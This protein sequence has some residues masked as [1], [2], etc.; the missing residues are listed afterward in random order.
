LALSRFLRVLKLQVLAACALLFWQSICFADDILTPQERTWLQAHPDIRVAISP[1]YPPISF[2]DAHGKPTGLE[3]DYLALIEKR[4]NY[5]FKRV[6]PTLAQRSADKPE[7]KQADVVPT[8]ASTSDRLQYWYFTQPYLDFP[9]YLITQGNAPIKFSL[10][11]S[12]QKQVSVV[13]HYAV[14]EYLINKFPNVKVDKVDDTCIG[15]QHVSSGESA[16]ML[17]DLPV[18]NWCAKHHDLK[19]FKIAQTT[20]F[21]YQLS[22]ASRKD[23][24]ELASILE[25][26]LASIKQ[27]ERDEIYLRWN[28]NSLEEQTTFEKNKEWI[29]TGVFA[30]LGL[31]LYRLYRWDNKFKDSLDKHFNDASLFESTQAQHLAASKKIMQT[32][33]IAFVVMVLIIFSI[34]IFTYDYFEKKESNLLSIV[35]FVVVGMGLLGGFTLGSLWRRFQADASFS[36]LQNQTKQRELAERQLTQMDQRQLKQQQTLATLTR[37]QL[38]PWQVAED[39]YREIA[40]QAAETLEAERASV[41]LFDESQQQL[42]CMSMFIKSKQ[43]HTVVKPLLANL[44]PQYFKHLIAQRVVVADD[45]YTNPA[46]VEF[47]TGYLLENNIGAMLDGT[48]WLNNEIVGVVCIEHVGGT[49]EWTLDEQNFVGSLTDY[50]RVIIETCNRRAAEQALMQQTAQLEQI[51][52]ERTQALRESEGRYSYVIQHAPIPILVIAANGSIMD[53]NPEALLAGGYKREDVIGKNFIET[54][55]A[56][57]S[58][59][60]A[61]STAALILKGNDFRDVELVLQSSTGEKVEYLCSIGTTNLT[62][63]T[64]AGEMVAIAQDISQ[65]KVLQSSLIKAREAAESADRIKSMFVASMSHELRTPLNSIIGFLGVVL[66]GMSGELNVKQKDQLGRAY[67]SA[68]HLLWLI[69]DVID[70]SKI[71]AGFLQVHTE[72]VYLK[73]LFI[74]VEHAVSHLAEEKHLRLDI[75]CEDTLQLLTDRKRIYQAVLNVVSNALKYTEQGS[76]KVTATVKN[77]LLVIDVVDTGIGIKEADLKDLFKPFER[78]ESKLKVKTLGT[79]L[80]LY[81]SR[82]ILTQLL[83]GTIE[84]KSTF[85]E[86]STFTIKVPL[87][88]PAVVEQANA[89]ILEE[90]QLR[91]SNKKLS[92]KAIK[93]T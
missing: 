47:T 55:V 91:Q 72:K 65:Q 14:Y 22:V 54:I 58:R 73:Q 48:I 26:A 25:K 53:V 51:L 61:L 68:K 57:E 28:D 4:L 27:K 64:G 24:P 21:H 29:F 60:K 11:N 59:R 74:D 85:G 87:S 66:Q 77:A 83:G 69:S 2:L 63:S 46:T 8:F 41:W 18:A 92:K 78:I 35:E 71:E 19:N 1:D 31:L 90:P 16:G 89:S 88:A 44:L 52:E 17:A 40:Q 50:C 9:V 34:F 86:G 5:Q 39:I 80:G 43:L 32:N 23:W 67:H 20:G 33:I 84:V 13:G 56:K 93:G 10:E 79:G 82:K 45:A 70:I 42:E 3:H 36:Q 62:T 49:R 30:L 7:D 12:Q 38:R 76:V 81:L 37:S 75:D 6:I 15:L